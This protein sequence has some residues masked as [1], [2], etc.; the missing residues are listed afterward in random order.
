YTVNNPASNTGAII[1]I[2]LDM[3][4]PA[5]YH[6]PTYNS[7]LT[8]STER[9][10]KPTNVPFDEVL[11]DDKGYINLPN[12]ESIIPFG[13]QLPIGWDGDITA[14]GEAD[15]TAIGTNTSK[16]TIQPGQTENRLVLTS[17]NLPTIK[18]M[19][20]HPDW[21]L[22][23]NDEATMEQEQEAAQVTQALTITLPVLAPSAVYPGSRDQWSRFRDDINVAIQFGW[24]S[25]AAF[26]Q[27]VVNQLAAA[28]QILD[29]QGIAYIT[30]A[31][32]TLLNT[33]RQSNA[34]QRNTTAYDLLYLNTEALLK[35]A[36]PPASQP[37]QRQVIP[38]YTFTTAD[39]QTLPV[40]H[41]V[42]VTVQVVDQGDNDAPMRGVPL[43][44]YVDGVNSNQQFG[45]RTDLYG[46]LSFS[47]KGRK[48]GTDI[49][50]VGLPVIQPHAVVQ[51]EDS[52]PPPP[53]VTPLKIT[54]TVIWQ[55]GPDYTLDYFE[56][57]IIQW[58]GTGPIH[59]QDATKNI[60]NIAAGVSSITRYYISRTKPVDP[61]TAEVVHDRVVPPL[62]PGESND[63][64]GAMLSLPADLGPG[65]YFLTACANAKRIVGETNYD[66]N[67]Q[68]SQVIMVAKQTPPPDCSKAAPDAPLLWPPNH[69]M[70]SVAING[71]TNPGGLSF[72]VA[73]TAIQQDEPVNGLG[74]GDTAP[75]GA[76]VGSTTAQVRVERSGT[77]EGRLYFIAFKATN[78]AGGSCTGTVTVGV[79]H[80]K[81][82]KGL[83]V[84]TGDRYDSTVG[85][86]H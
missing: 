76:G 64:G 60:G 52:S 51:T 12:H 44:F 16:T 34:S 55:G 7:I 45:G 72:T 78:S 1:D 9:A 61:N 29:S 41:V 48:V 43:Q 58:S 15:F 70:K 33:I 10:G 83:P 42:T 11:Q 86:K 32:T 28:R 13:L 40:D 6:E 80:D 67:C 2:T 4:A 18:I 79:P 53:D 25:D 14:D 57:P 68:V 17:P 66:N 62:K 54:T 73:I 75:D 56:P 37:P 85:S 84:D 31:L 49:I 39:E 77:G 71:I 65:T 36:A 63:S 46:E 35:S 3:V 26:G 38:E 23:V 27:A 8:I 24:I 47:Y 82:H 81:S 30:P 59:M 69:K 19:T 21:D 5:T 22:V 74:D 50:H 20:L